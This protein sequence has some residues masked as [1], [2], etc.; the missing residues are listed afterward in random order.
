LLSFC[1]CFGFEFGFAFVLFLTVVLT[2]VLALASALILGLVVIGDGTNN[3]VGC[4]ASNR[5]WGKAGHLFF[6]FW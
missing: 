5:K 3:K 4:Q 1:F 6:L 2:V